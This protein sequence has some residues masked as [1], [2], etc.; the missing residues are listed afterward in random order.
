M[1]PN[2]QNVYS[3]QPQGVQQGPNNLPV[4]PGTG[5]IKNFNILN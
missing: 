5:I 1:Y 3:I 4:P 2:Q